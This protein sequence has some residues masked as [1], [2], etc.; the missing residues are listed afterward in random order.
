MKTLKNIYF[1]GLLV[2]LS[3]ALVAC[4]NTQ[5]TLPI[6]DNPVDIVDVMLLGK[7]TNVFG[8]SIAI[9]VITK[10]SGVSDKTVLTIDDDTIFDNDADRDIKVG[11]M[12][13]FIITGMVLESY[14]TQTVAKRIVATE[15]D[16]DNLIDLGEVVSEIFEGEYPMVII[17]TFENA[18]TVN[19]D[20]FF[21][22]ELDENPSTGY[23][24]RLIENNDIKLIGHDYI[25]N[26]VSGN[27]VG[28]G[29]KRYYGFIGESEGQ[30][31]IELELLSPG[32]GVSE[33][34][35]VTVI[36]K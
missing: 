11:N 9:D 14:P 6:N 16:N 33:V 36:I 32:G 7:V 26:M 31:V 27:V 20:D 22:I 2:I 30:F 21:V 23:I 28:S 3:F 35:E 34:K 18:T 5:D 24:W 17:S 29:G 4:S 8:N 12:V 15:D 25:P 19:K 10:G 13:T 1:I